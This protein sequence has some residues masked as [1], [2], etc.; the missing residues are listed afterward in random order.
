MR[1]TLILALG[2]LACSG[3][4][5]D[6]AASQS[7]GTDGTSGVDPLAWSVFEDGPYNQGHQNLAFTYTTPLGVDREIEVEVFYPTEDDSG[8]PVRYD[9][10]FVDPDTLGNATPAP[11]VHA[12]GYPVLI[13]SHGMCG[14]AGGAGF[15]TPR[16]VS[17]G[18]VV[19]APRH[20]G[21][22]LQ[23]GFPSC[24]YDSPAS[25]YIER[26]ADMKAAVDF[27]A[28]AAVLAGDLDLRAIGASGHSRGAYS[29]WAASGATFDP[30]QV[31][32]ACAGE[33]DAIPARSCTDDEAAVF[34][35][36]ELAD[37]RIV[38][39][40][41]LDGGIR[42]SWFGDAGH[43]SVFGPFVKLSQPD[44]DNGGK[45]ATFDSMT[46]ID[47]AWG[48]VEGACHESFNVV[49]SPSN[50]LQPCD[51]LDGDRGLE[52]TAVYAL[53][54]LRSAVLGD[55]DADVQGILDGTVE[56]DEAVTWQRRTE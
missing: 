2:L 16:L 34:L 23:E 17:Q 1:P 38:A 18:W 41:A 53:A 15:W 10:T 29:L 13:H 51:T 54:L 31:A 22:T 45:Q 11:P 37:D 52:L 49:V 19:I 4:S 27:V 35:S 30:D 46:G 40:L 42:R 56:V 21:D 25:H 24:S 12:G 44:D 9:G 14:I 48:A 47:Y 3:G 20:F 7:D 5:N 32:A 55:D 26:P 50:G 39:S 28:G 33:N 36:G 6:T 8:D 43:A